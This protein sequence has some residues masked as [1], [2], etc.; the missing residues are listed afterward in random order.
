M[1]YQHTIYQYELGFINCL[2]SG[3]IVNWR[4]SYALYKSIASTLS[5]IVQF[6]FV[7]Q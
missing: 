4:Y 2:C 6:L 3:G 1:I 7:I 5:V